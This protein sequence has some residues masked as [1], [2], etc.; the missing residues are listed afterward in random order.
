MKR[1][2]QSLLWTPAEAVQRYRRC[3]GRITDPAGFGIDP[4]L[5]D[6]SKS[7][8]RRQAFAD[9]IPSFDVIFS[10]AVN[11]DGRPFREGLLFLCD[12]TYR[13]SCS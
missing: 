11:G 5:G 9:R 6:T 8:I 1:I 10:S 2:D 7:E 4:L 12:I 13:L 3:G